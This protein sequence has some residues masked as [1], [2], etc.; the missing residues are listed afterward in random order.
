MK[1]ALMVA[2]TVLLALGMTAGAV[3][4]GIGNEM[5]S[6]PHYNL[7][8]IAA[9]KDKDVGDSMGHTLF[10][11]MNGHTK[12]YMTQDPGGQFYVVDRNG[13]D[14]TAEFNIAPGHYD[15]YARALGKPNRHVIITSFG[16]FEDDTGA[17][18]Y[19]LGDVRLDREKGKPQ[20]VNIN[21]LFYVDI[22]LVVDGVPVSYH[23]EWVFDIEELLQY[24]W[25]YDNHGLKLLQVRF[26]LRDEF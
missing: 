12:I 5:P 13:T 25:D 22:D 15:V 16:E 23:N 24:Y 4:A 7:N 26:Y 8:I 1:K 21:H 3:M 11:L 10:V 17:N 14:G 6:G 9:P 2:T 20:T 19:E 18:W